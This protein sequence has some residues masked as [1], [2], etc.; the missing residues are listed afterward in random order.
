MKVV[1][2]VLLGFVEAVNL[3]ARHFPIRLMFWLLIEIMGFLVSNHFL[4]S[5]AKR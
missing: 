1:K 4:F 3:L 5:V 2:A